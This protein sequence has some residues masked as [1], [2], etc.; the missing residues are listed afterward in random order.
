MKLKTILSALVLFG[1]ALGS[2]KGCSESR[3]Y[4][5]TKAA[6]EAQAGAE[7]AQNKA[8][9]VAMTDLNA[10]KYW[11]DVHDAC[12]NAA[13]YWYDVHDAWLKARD[14]W[15]KA[16]KAWAEFK[17]ES[18]GDEADVKL[19]AK[20]EAIAEDKVRHAEFRVEEAEKMKKKI[21]E[22]EEARA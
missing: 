17:D 13:K 21:K 2:C 22:P 14:A 3:I 9:S 15:L 20:N 16:K 5:I 12:V 11:N 19:G 18:V 10:A 6:W 7:K 4:K 1:F 8:E